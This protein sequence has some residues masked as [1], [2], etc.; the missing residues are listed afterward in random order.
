MPSHGSAEACEALPVNSKVARA[1]PSRSWCRSVRSKP[2]IIMAASTSLK[3]PALMSLIFPPPPSSAGVPMTWMRPLVGELGMVVDLDRE[4]FELVCEAVHRLRDGVLDCVHADLRI[5]E[6]VRASTT[7]GD[8]TAA[9]PS[10]RGLEAA[11]V[12]AKRFAGGL[13]LTDG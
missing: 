7:T 4:R 9:R 5:A 8:F 2:W 10:C 13:R 3:R 6:R 11:G 1:M 12:G